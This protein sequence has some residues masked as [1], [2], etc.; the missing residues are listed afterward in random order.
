MKIYPKTNFPIPF[1]QP[2]TT[3]V[4]KGDRAIAYDTAL[5]ISKIPSTWQLRP[6]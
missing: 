6:I 2:F 1:S 4:V 5:L 3:S